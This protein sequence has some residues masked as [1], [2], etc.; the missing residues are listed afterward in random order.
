MSGRSGSRSPGVSRR[1]L[2]GP[3]ATGKGPSVSPKSSQ[4]ESNGSRQTVRG[5]CR[6]RANDGGRIE[7]VGRNNLRP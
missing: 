3:D 1:R 2:R 5:R 4:P 6:Q 7:L